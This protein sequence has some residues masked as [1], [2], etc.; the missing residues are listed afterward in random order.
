MSPTELLLIVALAAS[1]IPGGRSVG[2]Q[3]LC[4]ATSGHACTDKAK[5]HKKHKP[6]KAPVP[7]PEIS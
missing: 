4:L 3:A 6:A 2:K 5:K 7:P 1:L